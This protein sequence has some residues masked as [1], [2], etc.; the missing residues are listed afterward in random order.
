MTQPVQTTG[1]TWLNEISSDGAFVR[2]ATSFR[3]AVS[4]D[5]SHL[6]AAEPNRYHLYVSHACPWAHRTLMV[7]AL[8]GLEDLISVD[9]VHPYL[10]DKGWS[11]DTDF[12]GATGDQVG[13]QS[14]LQQIYRAVSPDYAGVITVPVLFDK[15]LGTIV[16]NESSE[17]IRMFNTEFDA[18]ARHPEIDLYPEN[19]RSQIDAVND[20]IYP[21]INNGVYRSGFA[22]TQQ[23][24]E[25]AINEL[26]DAL[27]RVEQIL[28]GQ[29]FLCG[30]ALTEA[31][32]RLFPTLI[33]FDAVY[34][35]HFKC[36]RKLIAQYPAMHRYMAS[37]YRLPGIADTVDMEHIRFHYFF[38]H[39]HI[40]P[41]GIVPKGP[42]VLAAL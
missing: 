25:A 27:D 4:K 14:F 5:S 41:T 16:N 39:R 42:D 22:Q 6:H 21:S 19:L 1:N 32:V 23:A 10:T 11:F 9:V 37:I 40:N 20:W 8:K 31:D 36:N 26:F 35:T 12:D 13:A 3:G 29:Q 15:K 7:R 24:H 17:I 2:A 34:H 38:S 33:R 30:D 28:Q 18:F